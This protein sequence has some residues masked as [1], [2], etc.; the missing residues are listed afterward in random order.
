MIKFFRKIRQKLLS[1]NKFSKYMIYAIGEIILVVIGILIALQIN[2]WNENRKLQNQELSLLSEI[3]TN[4]IS[5]YKSLKKDSLYSQ[6][7]ILQYEKIENYIEQD[8]KYDIELDS[9]F[10]VLTFWSTPFIK[11]S[12]YNT[13][14]AKGLDL[15]QNERLRQ[16]IV[17]M[18]E[19]DLKSLINDYD[20]SEWNISS[21]A[22]T[23]FFAK[24]IRRLHKKSLELSRPNDFE[25]L[26]QNEEF[27]NILSM[28][29]RQRK[30]GQVFFGEVMLEMQQLIDEIEIELNSR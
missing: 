8:L 5:S 27:N 21:Q 15:I 1:E 20:K 6:S 3:R 7:D 23:P 25:E 13:L 17:D 14:Q 22:V 28:I 24:H 19:V 4:L 26:K 29:I 30:R 2:N 10:G 18:Y 11:S 9:A 16:N 12:A